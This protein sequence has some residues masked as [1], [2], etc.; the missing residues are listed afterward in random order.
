[1]YGRTDCMKWTN[2]WLETRLERER[3]QNLAIECIKWCIG[4]E[5]NILKMSSRRKG[6]KIV[7]K[8]HPSGVNF[9]GKGNE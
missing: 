1:M 3:D 5:K 9:G 7:R 8:R 6:S 2:K 4:F